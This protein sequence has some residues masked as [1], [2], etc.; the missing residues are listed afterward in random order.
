M[1]EDATASALHLVVQI[2]VDRLDP[3]FRVIPVL[4]RILEL[5]HV[6]GN[7]S[8]TKALDLRLADAISTVPWAHNIT[9]SNCPVLAH[10][11]V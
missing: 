3:S 4:S 11:K 6:D 9:Q 7:S 8:A 5:A 1:G 10:A 2:A